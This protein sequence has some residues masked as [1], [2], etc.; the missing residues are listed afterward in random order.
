MSHRLSLEKNLPGRRTRL[1][2]WMGLA[3]LA[4]AFALGALL[5][6]RKWP[7]LIVDFGLQLYLPWRL[8]DGAVLYRDLYY[9]AGGPL[10]QYWHAGLFRIFGPSLLVILISNLGITALMLL[11]IYRGFGQT[12]GVLCGFAT[13]LAVVGIFCFGQLSGVGNYNYATPYS[14]EMLHGLCLSIVALTCLVRWRKNQRLLPLAMAGLCLGFVALT[15]PDIFLALAAAMF[16]AFLLSAKAGAKFLIRSAIVLAVTAAVPLALFGLLFQFTTGQPDGWQLEFFGWRPLFIHGIVNGPYYQWC[17]GLDD[18]FGHLRN[19]AIHTLTLT[20][21][22]TICVWALYR[23]DHFPPAVHKITL[24]VLLLGL[25]AAAR[26]VD[27][28]TS[29]TALPV[30]CLVALALLWR[31]WRQR[32][33]TAF[34]PLLWMVFALFMLAKQGLFPR[35]AHTGFALA[36]PATVGA[37]FLLGW[38]LPAFL[39]E[40]YAV[41]ARLLRVFALAVLTVGMLSL[42]HVSMSF[43]QTKHLTVGQG[44]DL[45]IATGPVHG[46]EARAMNQAIGWIQT[47]LPPSATLAAIPQ[48]VMLNYL[49]RHSN[50]TPCLDWNPAMLAVYGK[51]NMNAALAAHPP[52]YVALVEW[53]PYEFNEKSFDS[54]HYGAGTLAWVRTNYVPVALFGGEPLRNGAFGIKLLKHV[55][56]GHP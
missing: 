35:L 25:L 39:E 20:T 22:V 9:M 23:T 52:D 54:E 49:T 47:N 28:T 45:I 12:G 6:W 50:S 51:T 41:S 44:P 38:E 21:A 34:F 48:G 33:E 11:A 8:S 36:M 3:V 29:G 56:A 14:H 18:P 43:Y 10:S 19:I 37:I 55:D 53:E 16:A 26:R 40:K 30:L 24:A 7:D 27:W 1:P 15:K 31:R 17:M 32:S 4:L 46:G 42:I 5:T 2:F 13:T